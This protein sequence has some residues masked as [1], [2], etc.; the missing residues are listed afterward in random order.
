MFAFPD[1]TLLEQVVRMGEQ[2]TLQ[3]ARAPLATHQAAL[4]LVL[5]DGVCTSYRVHT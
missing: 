1:S 5:D 2:S 3:Q 4:R